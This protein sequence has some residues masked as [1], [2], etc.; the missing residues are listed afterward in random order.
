[1]RRI[2]T[3]IGISVAIGLLVA[4]TTCTDRAEEVSPRI[5]V[6]EEFCAAEEVCFPGVSDDFFNPR[7]EATCLEVC[8]DAPQW[9]HEDCAKTITAEFRCFA[10]L[11]CEAWYITS[12]VGDESVRSCREE[13]L[14]DGNCVSRTGI[15]SMDD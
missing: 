13:A 11:T 9:G 14:A 2:S 12:T 15:A 6:C 1:M 5:S 3:L 10:S 4:T 7:D 8:N